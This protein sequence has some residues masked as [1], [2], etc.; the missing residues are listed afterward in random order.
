MILDAIIS[1][2]F[3]LLSIV[4]GVGLIVGVHR[5]TVSPVTAATLLLSVI[6]PMGMA[7]AVVDFLTSI[8][9]TP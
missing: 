5:R 8:P 2:L 7:G 4:A 6:L 3:L 9:G 1:K